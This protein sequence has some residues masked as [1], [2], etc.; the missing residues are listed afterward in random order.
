MSY[1]SRAHN[2]LNN[3]LSRGARS[4]S[5]ILGAGTNRS[6][7]AAASGEN[8]LGDCCLGSDTAYGHKAAAVGWSTYLN[9]LAKLWRGS[10]A[11]AAPTK[12][13]KEYYMLLGGLQCVEH[14]MEAM[15]RGEK[16]EQVCLDMVK[17]YNEQIRIARR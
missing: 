17:M 8:Y 12:V 16:A 10:G 5:N 6:C 1:A 7:F 2:C 3:Y 15:R 4:I 14:M 11:N 9:K 13:N